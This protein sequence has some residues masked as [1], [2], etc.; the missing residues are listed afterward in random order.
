MSR[1]ARRGVIVGTA[2]AAVLLCAASTAVAAQRYAAPNGSGSACSSGSPCAIGIAFTG[3][4]NG[5]EIIIA[6]GDY[7]AVTSTSVRTSRRLRA[8]SARAAPPRIH[9]ASGHYMDSGTNGS[10]L[11]YV[12]IEGVTPEPFNADNGSV[13]DQIWVHATGNNACLVYGTSARQR[14]LGQLRGRRR[15][16]RR[17]QRHVHAGTAQRDRRVDRRRRHR[18]RLPRLGGRQPHDQRDQRDRPRR[19]DGPLRPGHLAGQRDDQHRSF[20]LR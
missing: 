11:S 12:Q 19:L 17:R 9:F 10:R 8:R 7:N 6:A 4:N 20:E 14:L 15:D 13:A 5:D 2:C 1:G 16:Q 3:A 18:D